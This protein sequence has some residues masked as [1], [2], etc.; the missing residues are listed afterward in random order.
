MQRK[1]KAYKSAKNY[2]YPSKTII[3]YRDCFWQLI[4][5]ISGGVFFNLFY[6]IVE[7]KAK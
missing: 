7:D 2:K 3:G 5:S 4:N 1:K 6:K